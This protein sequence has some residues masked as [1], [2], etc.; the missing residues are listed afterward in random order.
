MQIWVVYSVIAAASYGLSAIPL[1]LAS[2]KGVAAAS[3]ILLLASCIGSL[4]GALLYFG[5]TGTGVI[6]IVDRS[7]L[8]YGVISGMISIIG[9]LAVIKALASPD[10]SVPNVMSLVNT[11]ILFTIVFSALLLQ[12]LPQGAGIIKICAGS[13]LIFAG[14]VVL[15]R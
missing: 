2:N 4:T 10:S 13:L 7:S 3:A 14:S 12:E 6:R 11:N 1:K 8:V 9:S 5:F 15:C